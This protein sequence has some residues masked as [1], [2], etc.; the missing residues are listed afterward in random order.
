M[1][2]EDCC[3]ALLAQILPTIDEQREGIC[4]D[5]GV[6]TFAFY[7]EVFAKLGFQTVAVEP[8][9]I[10]VLR[11]LCSR[12]KINLIEACVSEVSGSQTLHIGTFKGSENINLSSLESDWWGSSTKTVKVQSLT[13]SEVLS[14]VNAEKVTCIKID[15]EGAEFRI[16]K[17]FGALPKSLLPDVVMF[18]YGGGD[19][20]EGG[21][22]GWSEKF[23]SAT[24]EC[25]QIVKDSGYASSIII[26]SAKEANEIIFNLQSSNLDTR[27]IFPKASVYGN[28]IAIKGNASESLKIDDILEICAKYKDETINRVSS[29]KLPDKTKEI[30]NENLNKK[31]R[32]N[33]QATGEKSIID[34]LI[35]SK[36]IVFDVGANTGSWTQA[37]LNSHSDVK[38]HLFEPVPQTYQSLLHNISDRL[39]TGNIFPNNLAMG[40][41]EKLQKFYFY[42]EKPA[43]STFFRRFDVEKQYG[44]KPPKSFPVLATSLDLYCQRWG[45]ERISFLKIDV[46]GGE[47]EVLHGAENLLKKGKIDYIQFEYGG[48]FLDA[49]ITLQEVFEYL[50][51][52]RYSLFKISPKGLEYKPIFGPEDED[53]SYG[54]FLAVNERFLSNIL[55]EQPKMLD[56]TSLCQKHSVK[57]RGVIHIG[58]YEGK[59]VTQYQLMGAEKTLFIEANPVVFERLQGNIAGYPKARAVNCAVSNIDGTSTM[60]LTSLEQS[61]SILPLKKVKEHYPDIRETDKITVKTRRLDTLLQELELSASEFN[62]INLDIQGAELLALEGATNLLKHI[63]AI[64]T[65]V[66]YEELYEGCALIEQID[67]FL[68]QQGFERVA[69][70]TPYHPSWGDAFYVRKPVITMSTLGRNGRFAN[71]LFQ[72]AFL[73]IYARERDLRVEKIGRAS[74]RERV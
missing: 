19:R 53:Y 66:N 58:A 26:D 40:S 47:L 71:Q 55:G 67:D 28:I 22:K 52:N 31:Q 65:E 11:Q 18:E 54:N 21:Q 27:Q 8:L 1:Q 32:E 61:S 51:K 45:I 15:V 6:G 17:Q 48:T 68:E 49:K 3:Q 63:D 33:F 50:Q 34:R 42:E 30:G 16:I 9:P 46:E 25:L 23:V 57:P 72:Y 59:E 74:C 24:Y 44:I 20:K 5:I 7:C 13:L 69:T 37:V 2:V 56:I 43:W 70:T 10:D 38:I 14:R 12:H 29:K 64:N 73:K 62:I 39:K 60:Y 4:V 41:V 35:Q 36:D